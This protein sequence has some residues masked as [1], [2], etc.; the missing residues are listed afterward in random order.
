MENAPQIMRRP[1]IEFG[2]DGMSAS[3][4]ARNRPATSS[5]L[6]TPNRGTEHSL[7]L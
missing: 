7:N 4:E 3:P 1:F 2:T 6:R 5:G